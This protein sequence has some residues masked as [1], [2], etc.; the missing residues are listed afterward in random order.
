MKNYY[1]FAKYLHQWSDVDE[2]HF[3]FVNLF[4]KKKNYK[5]T[6]LMFERRLTNFIASL[7]LLLMFA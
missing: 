2:E 1:Y 4:A 7:S 5:R 3:I 6:N